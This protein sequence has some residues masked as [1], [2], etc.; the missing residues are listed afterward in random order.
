M[1]AGALVAVPWANGGGMTRVIA[2]RPGAFRLSLATIADAGPFS[3][4]PGFTR[5]FALVS[6]RVDLT[7]QSGTLDVRSAPVMFSG[8]EPMA[9]AL[10]DGTALALNL[11]VPDGA[12]PLA[13]VRHSGDGHRDAVAVFACAPVVVD[14]TVALDIHD[15]M[16][17]SGVVRVA[18][19]A[20]VV[21][22]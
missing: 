17:C 8:D 6:G 7:G 14:G 1:R 9:A 15:T 13:M 20:L 2:D 5:V 4:F 18:G 19:C 12:P 16:V 3:L 11:M 10:P 22:R 21:V